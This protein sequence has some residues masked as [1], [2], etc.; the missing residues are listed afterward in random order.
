MPERIPVAVIG[1][2][3]AGLAT[4]YH[5]AAKGIEHVV[6]ER[7]HVGET[8]RSRRWD[9]FNLVTPNWT[10]QLPGHPYDGDDPDGFMPRT[11][12]IEYFKRYA[13]AGAAPV[14]EGIEVSR[15]E[16]VGSGG[17]RLQLA[18]DVIEAHQVVVAT[19][20]FQ[21]PNRAGNS[22]D[23]VDSDMVQLHTDGYRNPDQLPDGAVLMVGSGQSGCQIAEELQLS[24][25]QV[26]LAAGRCGWVPRNLGGQD[27]AWW[28]RETGFYERTADQMPEPPNKFACNPQLTGKDGG[29]DLNLRTLA[30]AGVVITGRLR[31]FI[32][33][34]ALIT[35]DLSESVAQGDQFWA[36]LKQGFDDHARRSGLPVPEAEEPP[37]VPDAHLSELDLRTL[38][39]RSI[40]WAT[41]YRPDFG[42]IELPAFQSDGY[43][44]HER[45]VSSFAGLY[46][47]GLHWLHKPKS[48]L[49][50]GVGEDAQH[51]VGVIEQRT[52]VAARS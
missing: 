12:I 26:Y 31:G 23:S 10:V 8:W 45:G 52:S 40:I 14:K 19:G 49:L 24:G 16:A 38:G 15:L 36:K 17:F 2:G 9:T 37:P 51:V 43:P 39:V 25:R 30:A 46:F 5:L 11:E 48:A 3:Q 50:Y 18:D 32:D 34:K 6:L 22:T 33:H 7:G 20:A 42:W 28:L 41:G 27:I 47:V 13:A 21:R 4:S 44:V 1:A 35:D 29:H